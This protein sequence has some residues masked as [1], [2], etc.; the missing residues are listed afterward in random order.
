MNKS[1][2]ILALKRVKIARIF[3]IMIPCYFAE[4]KG[5]MMFLFL[6]FFHSLFRKEKQIFF[7]FHPPKNKTKRGFLHLMKKKLRGK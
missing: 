2:F 1:A 3:D 5:Y 4:K 7:S 6:F